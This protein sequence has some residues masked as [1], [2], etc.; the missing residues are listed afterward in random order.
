MRSVGG[1]YWNKGPAEIK[2]LTQAAQD[3]AAKCNP[4]AE[5]RLLSVLSSRIGLQVDGPC[6]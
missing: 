6:S 1:R 2:G 5:K 3:T 4:Q